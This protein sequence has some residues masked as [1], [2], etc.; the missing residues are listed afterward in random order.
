MQQAFSS[1]TV[2]GLS[3]L[4]LRVES[5]EFGAGIGGRELPVDTRLPRVAMEC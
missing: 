3:H 2:A 1:A 4:N 5:L